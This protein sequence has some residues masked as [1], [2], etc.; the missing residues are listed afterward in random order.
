MTGFYKLSLARLER[1]QQRGVGDL[2]INQKKDINREKM[3]GYQ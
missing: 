2:E 3:C 1:L